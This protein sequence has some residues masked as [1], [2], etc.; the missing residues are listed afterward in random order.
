MKHNHKWQYCEM[1]HI[2]GAMC[3]PEREDHTLLYF[4]C[5]CGKAKYVEE[6]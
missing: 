1:K 3:Y 6:K 4:V 5:E 2:N